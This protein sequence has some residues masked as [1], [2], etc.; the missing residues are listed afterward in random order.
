MPY[1]TDLIY[2]QKRLGSTPSHLLGWRQWNQVKGNHSVATA[3]LL[4]RLCYLPSMLPL[5]PHLTNI[6]W[7]TYPTY[8]C[9][10][11]L[12]LQVR[13]EG[14]QYQYSFYIVGTGWNPS[15]YEWKLHRS[16]RCLLYDF[17]TTYHLYYLPLLAYLPF[18][19]TMDDLLTTHFHHTCLRILSSNSSSSNT[20]TL[21]LCLPLLTC[22]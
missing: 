9:C 10:P 13:Q 7:L 5:T 4:F 1:S 3:L 14:I 12:L 6:Y 16:F 8:L 17:S 19:C 22:I 21:L 18:T 15:F 2:I 11:N 20:S